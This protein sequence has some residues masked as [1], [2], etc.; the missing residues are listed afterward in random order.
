MVTADECYT[1]GGVYR[2][3]DIVKSVNN[4]LLWATKRKGAGRERVRLNLHDGCNM[5]PCCICSTHEVLLTPNGSERGTIVT[6]L[7][8]LE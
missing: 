5:G 3:L 4:T 8:S 2:Y 7:V 6:R 1:G